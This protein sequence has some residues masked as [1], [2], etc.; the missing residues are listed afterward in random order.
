[1]GPVPGRESLD[2]DRHCAALLNFTEELGLFFEHYGLSRSS[3]RILGWL[4][5]CQPPHQ[6]AGDLAEALELSKGSISTNIRLLVQV[7]MVERLRLT[8]HPRD[9][10][11][12]RPGIW[13]E[14]MRQNT[15]RYRLMADTADRGLQLLAGEPAE[16][17]ERLQEMR[18]ILGFMEQEHERLISRWEQKGRSNS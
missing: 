8:G 13:T 15:D 10:Y 12:I 16:V 2:T 4:L 18:A 6:S 11:R 5:I 1:M 14:L 9:Y 17:T 3:G 7:G